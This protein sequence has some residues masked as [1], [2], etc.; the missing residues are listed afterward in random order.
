[1]EVNALSSWLIRDE[2]E[3]MKM[4]FDPN[5]TFEFDKNITLKIA[6]SKY[7]HNHPIVCFGTFHKLQY[8]KRLK[9]S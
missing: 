8:V 6:K 3:L 9:M 1:M 5:N 7:I 4:H 2:H